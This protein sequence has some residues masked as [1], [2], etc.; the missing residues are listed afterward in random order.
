MP[1][2]ETTSIP[3]PLGT[4]K[5]GEFKYKV[6]FFTSAMQDHTSLGRWSKWTG[7]ATAEFDHGT[8]CWGGP[9]RKMLIAFQCGVEEA[10]LD[11]LEPSRCV[12]E[13]VVSHPGACE[14]KDLD[15]L[16]EGTRVVGVRDE[17]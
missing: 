16:V 11:V 7:R 6:T 9:E 15:E 13:G 14:Q 5:V 1:T 3:K 17:L 2:P 8:M 4:H 12:Y 10:L